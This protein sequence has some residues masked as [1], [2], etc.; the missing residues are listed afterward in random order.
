MRAESRPA[1][2]VATYTCS[3]V[4]DRRPGGNSDP[5]VGRV[6]RGHHRGSEGVCPWVARAGRRSDLRIGGIG[7]WA[8]AALLVPS[9]LVWTARAARPAGPTFE[10]TVARNFR[11]WD[12]NHDNF[13]EIGEIDRLMNAPSI[14]GDEAAALATIKIRDRKLRAGERSRLVMGL[15][16]QSGRVESELLEPGPGGSWRPQLPPDRR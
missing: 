14:R 13:L 8:A 2:A 12:L 7:K 16:E 15:D 11:A 6:R 1:S 4:N 9:L 10:E 3:G 5:A